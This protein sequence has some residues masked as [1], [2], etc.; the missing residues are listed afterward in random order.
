LLSWPR[1]LTGGWFISAVASTGVAVNAH[2]LVV[3]E[4][5]RFLPEVVAAGAPMV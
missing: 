1:S 2:L 3:E 4:P 5:A